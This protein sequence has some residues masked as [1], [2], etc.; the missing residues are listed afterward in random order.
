MAKKILLLSILVLAFCI[1]SKSQELNVT[2]EAQNVL[3]FGQSNGSA[4]AIATGG[5]A[6]YEYLW[7]ISA[8]S[9]T[10]SEATNLSAGTHSVTV[11]DDNSLTLVADVDISQPDE[12]TINFINIEHVSCY[13]LSDGRIGVNPSG[14]TPGL[15]GYEYQWSDADATTYPLL[16]DIP[17]GIYSVTVTDNNGCAATASVE[18]TQLEM[19]YV[20]PLWGGTICQGETFSCSAFATGGYGPYDFVWQGSDNTTYYENEITVSPIS[21]TDYSLIVTDAN[22]CTSETMEITVN[23]NP[24]VSIDTIYSSSDEICFGETITVY[25]EVS[26]GTGGP[27]TISLENYGI[28]NVPFNIHPEESR[29]YNFTVSD[30]CGSPEDTDSIY[31]TVNP[32][33]EEIEVERTP[34]NG[35]LPFGTFGELSITE[36][37]VGTVYYILSN[38]QSITGEIEGTG[39]FLELGSNLTA[40]S[41]EVMSRN[42]ANDCEN[43]QYFGSFTNESGINSN[44]VEEFKLF[45]NP[46]KDVIYFENIP[47]NTR[48][49]IFDT[50]GSLLESGKIIDDKIKLNNYSSGTYFITLTSN[51][52]EISRKKFIVE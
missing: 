17:A 26:G 16:I 24:G 49:K 18:I 34:T 9:Q 20:T 52:V 51:K 43:S 48:Y 32:R 29:W 3:C 27:Y 42:I 33:P 41:Y 31:I 40:G 30:N 13:G 21:T 37:E 12:L 46:A 22:N 19:I 28:I 39:E 7:G 35:I 47:K 36:S 5:T 45:P 10:T 44:S 2:F 50:K 25:M 6:P 1:T 8:G 11:T 38:G 23:V 14:G 4:E 15:T